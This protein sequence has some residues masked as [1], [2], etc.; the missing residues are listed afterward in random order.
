MPPSITFSMP[1]MASVLK[2]LPHIRFPFTSMIISLICYTGFDEAY[3]NFDFYKF[4][5][6]GVKHALQFQ[7][8]FTY[9][10]I[11]CDVGRKNLLTKKLFLGIDQR[12]QTQNWYH[13]S[14]HDCGSTEIDSGSQINAFAVETTRMEPSTRARFK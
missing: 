10:N 13:E 6:Y 2:H 8:A 7:T 1:Y 4:F 12:N 3:P 11:G 14:L 5:V 9:T